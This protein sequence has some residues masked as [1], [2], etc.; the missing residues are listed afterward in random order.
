LRDLWAAKQYLKAL[1]LASSWR[2]LGDKATRGAIKTGHAAASNPQIYSEMKRD[3][4]EL[5]LDGLAALAKRYNLTQGPYNE[6][7]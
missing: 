1:A 3:P 4:R 2:E 5:V 7:L 6:V